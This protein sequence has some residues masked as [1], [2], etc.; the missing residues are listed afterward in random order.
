M[1]PEENLQENMEEAGRGILMLARDEL[2]LSMRFL[3]VALSSF[4]YVLDPGVESVGTDGNIIY[5]EIG[6]LAGW[7]SRDRIYVNRMYLHMLFHCIFRHMVLIAGKDMRLRNLSCDIAVE[8]LMDEWYVRP[9]RRGKSLLRRETYGKFKKDIQ[10][11]NAQSIYRYFQKTQFEEKEIQKLENEFL[12]DDHRLWYKNNNPEMQQEINQKWQD[13]SESMETDMQTFSKEASADAGDFVKQ[14]EI[15]NKDRYDY[16][17]FLQK[18]SVLGEEITVDEDSFD[19]IFYSY[20]LRM[21][22]NMPLIEPQEW[23][24]V[25]KIQDFVIV[26]D[27]SMSCSGELVKSFLEETYS[28]LMENESFFHKV[29]IHIVQCDEKIQDDKKITDETELKE[30]MEHLDLKGEGG[31]DFRPAFTYINELVSKGE[32]HQLKG[33]LYF[34]DG[35]GIFPKK[36]PNYETAFVM[37]Q[38]DY[39]EVEV[40][41]WAMKLTVD[42]DDLEEMKHEH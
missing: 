8:A 17:R 41:S 6:K 27:T 26:I 28:I 30:Y 12:V 21:Y 22:E 14:M 10:V 32:F 42:L 20:G 33:V 36:M 15:A 24:E 1:G 9:I 13:I 4:D 2:Y 23:K 11:M 5:Y 7:F 37:L 25:K 34:T 16:R 29:N 31:T 35:Q 39:E 40:P 38:D 18:F 19:Y 3:D